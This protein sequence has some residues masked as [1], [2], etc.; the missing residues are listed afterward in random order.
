MPALF[1]K[2]FIA[3]FAIAILGI[4]AI[5]PFHRK[6]FQGNISDRSA[7]RLSAL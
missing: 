1:K 7:K 2:Y 5:K 3:I 4:I 6:A